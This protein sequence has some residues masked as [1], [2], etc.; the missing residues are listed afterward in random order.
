VNAGDFVSWLSAR[1]C[2]REFAKKEN[3]VMEEKVVSEKSVDV[4]LDYVESAKAL[5]TKVYGFDNQTLLIDFTEPME[6][7]STLEGPCSGILSVVN[8]YLPPTC[9]DVSHQLSIGELKKRV[10]SVIGRP[11]EKGSLLFTGVKMDNLSVQKTSHKGMTVYVLVTAGV[12]TNALR[13]SVDDGA[14]YEPGTI[15]TII[16][17]NMKLSG[18]AMARAIV[19]ATEAKTAAM[20]D[21]D[22]RS[23][24]QPGK[25]QATGTG[26]DNMIVVQGKGTSIENAGGH[27]KMGE[28]I[29]KA[30]YQGVRESVRLQDGKV[31]PRNVF[32]RLKERNLSTYDLA[33]ACA[34]DCG[35]D[36]SE[37]AG[38][39]EELLLQKRYAGL[40]EAALSLSDAR[41]R[42]LVS[43]LSLHESSCQQVAAEI[44]GTEGCEVKSLSLPSDMPP[45]LR[46]SLNALLNGLSLR[47]QK[48][49]ASPEGASRREELR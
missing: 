13:M 2:T 9:W 43:D 17:T 21:L 37:L 39:L 27:S 26:T 1:V 44:A 40:I 5:D 10:H 16:L 22:I 48:G 15:N 20:Q 33:R 30:V 6:V 47:E 34:E 3:L 28:L 41:G 7:L 14:Y 31:G 36:A 25:H 49:K 38:K 19:S 4:R 23:G 11:E 45:V 8:H 29:A 42:G 35:G 12:T 32:Q 46:T 18:R 24:S